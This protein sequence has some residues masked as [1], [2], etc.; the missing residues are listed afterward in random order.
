MW[1]VDCRP[2]DEAYNE[3]ANW[4]CGE[5]ILGNCHSDGDNLGVRVEKPML[6]A[7]FSGCWDPNRMC[8]PDF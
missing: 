2:P 6:G 7:N 1:I 8:L 5:I 3:A 4:M